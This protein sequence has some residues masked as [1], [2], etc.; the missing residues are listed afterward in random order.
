MKQKYQ[1]LGFIEARY[2]IFSPFRSLVVMSETWHIKVR[3]FNPC[4]AFVGILWYLSEG[5]DN[6]QSPSSVD[7]PRNVIIT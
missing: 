6:F 5:D 7:S 1:K 2:G 3:V 4:L